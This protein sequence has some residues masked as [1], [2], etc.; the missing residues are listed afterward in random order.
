MKFSSD[1]KRLLKRIQEILR[2]Q[3]SSR[4]PT[5]YSLRTELVATSQ[6]YLVV[7]EG[8]RDGGRGV[9]CWSREWLLLKE[10]NP[11]NNEMLA[12]ALATIHPV[13]RRWKTNHRR[14]LVHS[15]YSWGHEEFRGRRWSKKLL[16]EIKQWLRQED[17]TFAEREAKAIRRYD[18]ADTFATDMVSAA[19]ATGFRWSGTFRDDPD[20]ITNIIGKWNTIT[21][22]DRCTDKL[23]FI[24]RKDKKVRVSMKD[25]DFS[26][27]E[28]LILMEAMK[29]IHDHRE[30][31]A[32]AAEVAA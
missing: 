24:P 12:V 2:N 15:K 6:H 30:Q 1:N 20:E 4:R 9:S 10:G 16:A 25:V 31:L 13:H 17:A 27:E 11:G 26:P 8:P 7:R 14:D 22:S 23:R 28:F 32:E 29:K 18:N 19:K 5:D 21:L 3:I